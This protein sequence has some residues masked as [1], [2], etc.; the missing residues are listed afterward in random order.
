MWTLRIDQIKVV[1]D[2]KIQGAPGAGASEDQDV[3]DRSDR[4]SINLVEILLKIETGV[5]NPMGDI[6]PGGVGF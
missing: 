4:I 5:F 6:N 2:L 3:R 1:L